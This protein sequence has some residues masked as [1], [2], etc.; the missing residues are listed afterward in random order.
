MQLLFGFSQAALFYH[1]FEGPKS[2]RNT[3]A[4]GGQAYYTAVGCF[5]YLRVFGIDFI[6]NES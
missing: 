2:E 3:P 6:P 5:S 1:Q 4:E